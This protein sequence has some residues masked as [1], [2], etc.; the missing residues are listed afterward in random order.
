MRDSI[1]T[2]LLGALVIGLTVASVAWAIWT[3][4]YVFERIR[5]PD[6]VDAILWALTAVGVVC[7]CHSVGRLVLAITDKA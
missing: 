2:A 5:C 4:T 3:T 1:K 7:L 6:A